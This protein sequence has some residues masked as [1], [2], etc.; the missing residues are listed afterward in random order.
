MRVSLTALRRAALPAWSATLSLAIVFPLLGHGFTLSYDM[1]FAPTQY[2]VPDA[3]GT[4][5]ALARSVPADAVV[6]LATTVLPG[7]V[8]QQLIL[9]GALFA[10]ALGAGLL[11]PT[12]ST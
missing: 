2:L 9:F 4:G 5:S 8:V 1:V 6:A 7:D 12:R 11:V 10:A 3:I